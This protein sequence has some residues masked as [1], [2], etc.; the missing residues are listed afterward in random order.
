M[1]EVSGIV[2]PETQ[3]QSFGT[4]SESLTPADFVQKLNLF[5]RYYIDSLVAHSY[6]YG[7]VNKLKFLCIRMSPAMA[8]FHAGG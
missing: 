2:V 7:L 3:K 5:S 6:I 8:G 1:S 4:A